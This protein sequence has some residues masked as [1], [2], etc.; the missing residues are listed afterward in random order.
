MSHEFDCPHCGAAVPERAAACPECGSDDDTGWSSNAYDAEYE[1][2]EFDYDAYIARE[3]PEGT[4]WRAS[5]PFWI[6]AV[7]GLL[8][9]AFL[10]QLLAF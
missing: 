2:D 8:L 4:P 6:F 10:L 9:L 3:F 1:E 7:A 5:T